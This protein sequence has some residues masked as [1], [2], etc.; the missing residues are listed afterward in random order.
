[1]RH[2]VDTKQLRGFGLIVGGI[3]GVIGL[4]PL[5]LR[6]EAPRWAAASFAGFLTISALILPR[7]LGPFHRLWMTI[8]RGL[9]WANTRIILGAIFYGL[10]TPMGV[11]IRLLRRDPMRRG[12]EPGAETYRVLRQPRPAL[13][14]KRQF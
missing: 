8:G 12:F 7:I 14:M 9:E 10:I 6:D 13:H 11:S 4:W 3:F 1:M 2:G 5:I